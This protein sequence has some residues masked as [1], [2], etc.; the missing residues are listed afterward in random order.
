MPPLSAESA[1][2]ELLS[3]PTEHFTAVIELHL[4]ATAVYKEYKQTISIM[5][6]AKVENFSLS[7][8]SLYFR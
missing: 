5:T 6:D 1:G 2:G 3:G 7:W 8:V 4:K